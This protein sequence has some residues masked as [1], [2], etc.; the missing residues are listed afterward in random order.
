MLDSKIKSPETLF[1]VCKYFYHYSQQ[2]Y[3]KLMAYVPLFW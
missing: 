3:P 1:L 2:T